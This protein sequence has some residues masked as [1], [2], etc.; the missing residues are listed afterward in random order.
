MIKTWEDSLTDEERASVIIKNIYGKFWIGPV[1]DFEKASKMS[2]DR[3]LHHLNYSGLIEGP[4][5]SQ[6]KAQLFMN[7]F[8]ITRCCIA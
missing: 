3:G 6:D 4:F 8:I 1:K 7:K 2:K 5:D